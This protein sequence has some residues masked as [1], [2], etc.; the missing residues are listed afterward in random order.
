M[1]GGGGDA[2]LQAAQPHA[3]VL[4]GGNVGLQAAEAFLA[5]G[6]RVTVVAASPHLLSQMVDAEAGRRLANLFRARFARVREGA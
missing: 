1:P 2:G 4:G 3:I 5:R 6:L